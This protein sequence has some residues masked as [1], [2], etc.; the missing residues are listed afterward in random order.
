MDDCVENESTKTLKLPKSV[1]YSYNSSSNLILHRHVEETSGSCMAKN[2][3]H[4]AGVNKK[5][6]Y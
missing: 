1:H 4:S 2:R 5:S 3:M 6:C